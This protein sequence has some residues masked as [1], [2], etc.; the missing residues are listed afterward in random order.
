M[1][2]IPMQDESDTDLGCTTMD[3]E[4]H[5]QGAPGLSHWQGYEKTPE[6]GGGQRIRT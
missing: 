1:F 5:S 2:D 3:K 4:E 6:G